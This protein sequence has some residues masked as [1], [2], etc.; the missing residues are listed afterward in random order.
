VRLQGQFGRKPEDLFAIPGLPANVYQNLHDGFEEANVARPV[1]A[2]A[3]E[4][5]Q[6]VQF[7]EEEAEMDEENIDFQA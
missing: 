4:I 1:V 6:T 5:A 2:V 3:S 7:E